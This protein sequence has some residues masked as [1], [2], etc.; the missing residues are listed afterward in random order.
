[1]E[2]KTLK[3]LLTIYIIYSLVKFYEFFFRKDEVKMKGLELVY[4]K[5][6]GRIIRIFDSVI[7]ILMIVFMLLLLLSG[8]EY[9]SFTTGLLVGM[10]I[11]QV[12]FHRFSEPLPPEKSPKPPVTALKL[13]SYSIQANPGKAWRELILMTLIFLW[14]LYMLATKGFGLF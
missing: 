7:L 11:I 4:E 13:M 3:I 8:V 6:G 14:S 1:M 5:G 2:Q 10:T 12:F 9:L